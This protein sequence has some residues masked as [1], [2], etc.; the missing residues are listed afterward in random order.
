MLRLTSLK[1]ISILL[2]V[3]CGTQQPVQ[4]DEPGVRPYGHIEYCNRNPGSE[5]CVQ[6]EDE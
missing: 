3:G 4:T 5:F 1:L 2:L 6:K